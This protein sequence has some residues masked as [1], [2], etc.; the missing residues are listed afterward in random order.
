M[1]RPTCA[2]LLL[3]VSAAWAAEAPESP[4][5]GEPAAA[6]PAP[7]VTGSAE[8]RTSIYTAFRRAFFAGQYDAALPLA[9][10]VVELT[11]TQYGAEAPQ[12]ANPLTN[13]GTT[14]YRM[15]NYDAA[16]EAYAEA[17]KL[18]ELQG[19]A[20]NE[21][22]VRP[23]HGMGASLRGQ[24]RDSDAIAP[25]KR[26]VE[27]V[28]NRQGLHSVSQLPL[29]RELIGCYMST[30]RM[31]EAGREQQYAYGVAETAY[32]K[33]DSRMVGPLEDYARW[34]EAAGGYT[35]ARA[36]HVRAIQ[37]VD[38]K[39]GGKSLEAIPA[40]RGVARTY[41]LAFLHGEV[42]EQ[43]QSAMSLQDQLAPSLIARA[44]AAPSS[45]G[46]RALRNA[47]D[48][49]AAAP[50]PQEQLRGAVLIDLGD[51]YLTADL[52]P[53]AVSTWREAWKALGPEEG[54]RLLG[55]PQ[56]VVYR[57]PPIAVSRH[58]YDPAEYEE[59]DV[60]LKVNVEADG[61]VREAIVTNAAP[62]RESAEK[63][64]IAAVKRARWRPAFREGEPVA[65]PEA[66]F[67]EPVY[68]RPPRE[69]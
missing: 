58:Q 44:S 65:M 60:L 30:G 34:H 35:A 31:T 32:G 12:L 55:V 20:A 24:Q 37:I 41:R 69:K 43:V 10:R 68:V 61:D 11:R 21:K 39:L 29:L 9:Q 51:W 13:L 57:P 2:I 46:E 15:R 48:R 38:D 22:M 28:R 19:E 63:A 5:G 64:V 27:I 14:H 62:Q 23:L 16:L 49:L 45:E 25:F 67:R 52:Q 4:A 1:L 18:L 54:Q 53:R 36:L 56:P 7:Q 42:Q 3:G 17:M 47:L 8:D 59:Q 50:V 33:D 26:A 66:A 6:E 40:L